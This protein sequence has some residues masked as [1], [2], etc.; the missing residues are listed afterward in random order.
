MFSAQCKHV[1]CV[2]LTEQGDGSNRHRL[3]GL[4]EWT[5][6]ANEVELI[7]VPGREPT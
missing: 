6:N 2:K 7:P 3:V 1:V 5:K 4:L